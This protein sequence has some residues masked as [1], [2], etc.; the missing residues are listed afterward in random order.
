[1]DAEPDWYVKQVME[2][3]VVRAARIR[4]GGVDT[5]VDNFLK[6][7]HEEDYSDQMQG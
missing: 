5:S 7:T 6:I 3:F 2:D 4:G 1:M